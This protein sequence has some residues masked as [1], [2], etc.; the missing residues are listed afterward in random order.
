MSNYKVLITFAVLVEEENE[1]KAKEYGY[2]LVKS[3]SFDW[4]ED[5]EVVEENGGW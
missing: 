3:G 4:V 1:E 2:E 5:V